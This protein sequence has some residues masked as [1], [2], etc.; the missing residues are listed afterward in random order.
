ML[1][2]PYC[3]PSDKK[4]LHD[5]VSLRL[6]KMDA[7]IDSCTCIRAPGRPGGEIAGVAGRVNY[8][9]ADMRASKIRDCD[10]TGNMIG[11]QLDGSEIFNTKFT[12]ADL[13][14]SSA[15]NAH[16][17]SAVFD[18]CYLIGAIIDHSQIA[19]TQLRDCNTH[20]AT[21][22]MSNLE[23]VSVTRGKMT[24]A[25]MKA[26]FAVECKLSG[27]DLS[28][29]AAEYTRWE[30]CEILDCNLSGTD[31]R[32]ARFQQCSLD[33]LLLDDAEFAHA[34]FIRC[35]MVAANFSSALVQTAIFDQCDLRGANFRDRNLLNA[36]LT[37]CNLSGASFRNAVLQRAD[38]SGSD[39]S[40]ANFAGASYDHATIWPDG[41]QPPENT[42]D[43]KEQIDASKVLM[44]LRKKYVGNVEQPVN[45]V[46]ASINEVVVFTAREPETHVEFVYRSFPGFFLTHSNRWALPITLL[47]DLLIEAAYTVKQQSRKGDGVMPF[48]NESEQYACILYHMRQ[49]ATES[50]IQAQYDAA[51]AVL[52]HPADKVIDWI[53]QETKAS[54]RNARPR[55]S[56]KK[57]QANA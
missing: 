49:V 44:E 30:K 17:N 33:N 37:N 40:G 35:A 3:L 8:E 31:F 56:K 43:S 54:M 29:T 23:R 46:H 41:F 36:S 39:L 15:P 45:S 11:I 19:D 1:D 16:I 7:H 28:N 13:A 2:C 21:A 4:R 25:D 27:T 6:H 14:S 9:D 22:F 18:E 10:L 42:F 55:R 12:K 20:H 26:L 48:T 38:F 24:S 53:V 51:E 32:N 50:I 52:K 34:H 5:N 57:S 47:V